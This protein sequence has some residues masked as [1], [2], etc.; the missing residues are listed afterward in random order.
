MASFDLAGAVRERRPRMRS[1]GLREIAPT[2]A[3]ERELQA[4]IGRV[5]EHWAEAVARE[6][7]PA[8]EREIEQLRAV[9][10]GSTVGDTAPERLAA[11]IAGA[12][13]GATRLV[14]SLAPS[15]RSWIVRVERWHRQRWVAGVR[16]VTGIDIGTFIRGLDAEP[17][18]ATFQQWASGLIRDVSDDA[19]RK[20]EASTFRA[21]AEMRPRADFAKEIGTVLDTSRK[22]ALLI[23]RDQTNKLSGKLD[24]L[25]H[26]EAGIEEYRW[27]TALDDR[28]RPTHRANEGKIFR[29]D[30][31]PAST[32]HPRTEINCFPGSHLADLDGRVVRA[33]R[34]WY[35]GE[36]TEI[37]TASGAR[38]ETTPNHPILTG[39]GWAPAH[40]IKIGD[41]LFKAEREPQ[42]VNAD[43]VEQRQPR[44]SDLFAA[45]GALGSTS[46][47]GGGGADF[48]GDGSIDQD[49]DVVDL[50][51][52]LL[53][54]LHAASAEA[55][56]EDVLEEALMGLARASRPGARDLLAGAVPSVPDRLM[57]AGGEAAAFLW[58]QALH[59]N[60][61][62][63]AGV[64]QAYAGTAERAGD[65]GARYAKALAEC[66]NALAC[67]VA[68]HKI[69][70]I[71]LYAIVSGPLHRLRE[72]VSPR[73]EMLAERVRAES[74]LRANDLQGFAGLYSGDAVV[75]VSVARG[76]S[77][78]VYNLETGNNW[79][80]VNSTVVSNCR[81]T[82]QPWIKLLDEIEET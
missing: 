11:I 53:A 67:L 82:A 61:T 25:R 39:R 62:G 1:R 40:A 46:R 71:D 28:V 9:R 29:W 18:V 5:V 50:D 15:I 76:W 41:D 63:L 55:F 35:E 2:R 3:M 16:A 57:R 43:D 24:E 69:V 44:L 74:N 72:E 78:H 65:G 77:G 19:R 14:V 13:E 70:A 49:V 56:G 34:R 58:A 66:K 64:A 38:L 80:L 30:T 33:Y 73:S 8:Y 75:Q 32:G 60:P 51:R 10:D 27:R 68:P 81:C 6:I 79:F 42:L 37:V 12:A 22:R 21:V 54:D 36:L 45:L 31:P 7:A 23:A 59:A 47:V 52:G 17:E 20:I 48:H 4:I 26:R